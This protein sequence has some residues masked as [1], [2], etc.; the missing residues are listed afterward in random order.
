MKL[1]ERVNNLSCRIGE[2]RIRLDVLEG[3]WPPKE[4]TCCCPQD[5]INATVCLHRSK[6]G[7]CCHPHND[8]TVSNFD[9]GKVEKATLQC[10]K[11]GYE[12]GHKV[13]YAE[14]ME[15]NE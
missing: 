11:E 15:V 9:T 8:R 2:I 6:K 4:E 10:Y 1:W 14:G 7:N 13:G 5:S 12:E 3:T